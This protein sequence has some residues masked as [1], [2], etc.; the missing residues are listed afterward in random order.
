MGIYN[1]SS[2]QQRIWLLQQNSSKILWSVGALKIEGLLDT[3]K[4]ENCINNIIQSNDILSTNYIIKPG[5]LFPYQQVNAT[6]KTKLR[7][8]DLSFIKTFEDQLQEINRIVFLE[9]KEPIEYTKDC[10]VRPILFH[11]SEH[12]NFLYIIVPSI[13]IDSYSMTI[14]LKDIALY[15]INKNEVL[16]DVIQYPQFAGWH[17]SLQEDPEKEAIDFWNTNN[18]DN[19]FDHLFNHYKNLNQVST[20]TVDI[21]G[22]IKTAIENIANELECSIFSV[23]LSGLMTLKYLSSKT[24]ELIG[25]TLS[26]RAHEELK[27]TY[28]L[29]SKTIP[30]GLNNFEDFNFKELVIYIENF[31]HEA[32]SL[33]DYFSP[34][35]FSPKLNNELSC[36]SLIT[37]YINVGDKLINND[38]NF[39]IKDIYCNNEFYKLKLGFIE[40][41]KYLKINYIFNDN[42]FNK[43]EICK[44]HENY[45][46]LL[47]Y[48]LDHLSNSLSELSSFKSNQIENTE[49]YTDNFNS[50]NLYTTIS[51]LF[52]QQVAQSPDKVAAVYNNKQ[53]TYHDL[54]NKA[55]RIAVKLRS[56]GVTA[57]DVVAILGDRS[58][59]MIVSILGII[60]A[61]GAFLPIDLSYPEERIKYM[62][63]DS[64]VNTLLITS[65]ELPIA[66]E[67]YNDNP[68]F[69]DEL[70][71]E[72]S[73]IINVIDDIN[74]VH[75][76]VYVMYTSG[77]TGN[78]KGV[79]IEHKNLHS[80]ISSLDKIIY[81]ENKKELNIGLISSFSFDGSIK[82]IFSSLLLGH[83]LHI[84]PDEIKRDGTSLIQYFVDN[85]IDITDITPMYLD[86]LLSDSIALPEIDIKYFLC[87]GQ[88]LQ[89]KTVNL[90]HEKYPETTIVNLYGP[91]ECCV[92][93]TYYVIDPE[94][95][96]KSS[97][98]PIGYPLQNT[99]IYIL[100]EQQKPVPTGIIGEIYIG[101][102]GVARGY[103][104]KE[105]LTNERF[106]HLP[107]S[108]YRLYRTGDL[109]KLN[110]DNT[111]EFLSR[112][113]NQ[114]KIRG[115]RVELD[116]IRKVILN[117]DEVTDCYVTVGKKENVKDQIIAYLVLNNEID[118][119]NF[120][121]SLGKYLPEFMIPSHLVRAKKFNINING[122]IDVNTLP[123]IEQNLIKN[124]N[125]HEEPRN[126]LEQAL[127]NIIKDL[128][129]LDKVNIHDNF[130]DLGM[131][132]IKVLQ[133]LAQLAKKGYHFPVNELFSNPTI[134]KLSSIHSL[135]SSSIT[136]TTVEGEL[137]LS[138]IQ[139]EFFSAGDVAPH[140][141]NQS[142]V[143][144]VV[145]K[146]D[147]KDI[148]QIFTK[149]VEHHDQ[150]RAVFRSDSNNEIRQ[151]IIAPPSDIDIEVFDYSQQPYSV[152]ESS[153]YDK[154]LLM[155]QSISLEDGLLIKI[156]IF[157][158]EDCN[159]I[160]ISMHH[161][162]C[163]AYS[164][165]ILLEDIE[166]LYLQLKRDQSLELP[167][168]TDSYKDWIDKLYYHSNTDDFF[169]KSQY[170]SDIVKTN[171][172][173]LP[174]DQI[175]NTCFNYDS[176]FIRREID[177]PEIKVN[178][179]LKK[180]ILPAFG[181][182]VKNIFKLNKIGL[183]IY[184]IG[185]D[186]TFTN[187]NI[188]RS[189]G[190]FTCMYPFVIDT[191]ISNNII[192]IVEKVSHDF[193]KI[194]DKGIGY[195]MLKH[196]SNNY[197]YT[198]ELQPNILLNHLGRSNSSE[199]E[200][201]YVVEDVNKHH[202]SQ[203]RKQRFDI[204]ITT[205]ITNNKLGITI[206][207]NHKQYSEN[208]IA[209]LM[210][211]FEEH[212]KIITEQQKE[213]KLEF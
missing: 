94:T 50:K 2:L 47:T 4:L 60:K 156:G 113:D 62:L 155:Q 163:D 145:N 108:Q 169:L 139:K 12:L 116:E 170:W 56:S 149:I 126:E 69:I 176:V 202:I 63:K 103:I 70:L 105:E 93:S 34:I 104:N 61:G 134:S 42:D 213:V 28:G 58:L 146:I 73:N 151:Y 207:F 135:N 159:K 166:T 91:T 109:G 23:L 212:I 143:L 186:E 198:S 121:H 119:E 5:I 162:I 137:K 52:Q 82:Q 59:N 164:W 120:R 199:G 129:N 40:Y 184:G 136:Q 101:G 68:I 29:I 112:N 122:K 55:N 66:Y 180:I 65:S 140:H 125:K 131:D 189:I 30:F 17:D 130:Y 111:I 21:S 89:T 25:V 32:S 210:H 205:R 209:E 75:D 187:L 100:N 24:K 144:K 133:L 174:K 95:K 168:K 138:P 99:V 67:K 1:I 158:F 107:F 127:A 161:L 96:L 35:E 83:T 10:L 45:I 38:I 74:D 57:N 194:P 152:N 49:L 200:L 193:D 204:M 165:G 76:M 167:S 160:F 157:K 64:S 51:T 182:A 19:S 178:G 150:L 84:I 9:E 154:M 79:M 3:E 118:L 31:T 171:I 110:Y 142:M 147:E 37:E 124:Q 97:N 208:L 196:M 195:G 16:E 206:E 173:N 53:L 98:A 177:L 41:D 191:S 175:E 172:E 81:Q 179:D 128:K 87:G 7:T 117:V 197:C 20:V 14:F 181:M 211:S 27:H 77:S 114:V 92:D 11:L 132:S 115:Y 106:V 22:Q 13:S 71:K 203:G 90:L 123:D 36:Y 46:D 188:S 26:E 18:Y 6:V 86:A 8:I 48:A 183:N 80:L 201:E 141:F 54:N 153:Y 190:W 43:N 148:K 15:Y 88:Q 102:E 72:E 192:N 33:Q 78:P 185:R 39:E 44:F 85:K